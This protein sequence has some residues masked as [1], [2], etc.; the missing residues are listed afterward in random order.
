MTAVWSGPFKCNPSIKVCVGKSKGEYVVDTIS[1]GSPPPKKTKKY[2][3]KQEI[4][5]NGSAAA[6]I[7][8]NVG[9]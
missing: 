2:I 1:I 3:Y 6:D 5:L 7:G 8:L 4:D 9:S